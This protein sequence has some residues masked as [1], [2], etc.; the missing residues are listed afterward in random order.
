ME[1][2]FGILLLVMAVV[3]VVLILVQSSKDHR[4]SGTITGSAENFFG[5]QKGKQVDAIL[6]K[7]TAVICVIFF[8]VVIVT[9]IVIT[10]NTDYND[11]IVD[12]DSL[13]S[14]DE[15]TGGENAT[16]EG[17]N[18]EGEDVAPEGDVTD[19]QTVDGGE[20]AEE[21]ERNLGVAED[22]AENDNEIADQWDI[23]E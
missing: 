16:T 1:L 2:F 11:N 9:Y 21:D 10:P 4:M 15:L 6:N 22:G 23:A 20:V 17:E 19:D 13:I 7:A 5:K 18:S 8:I 12:L 14:Q 3:L